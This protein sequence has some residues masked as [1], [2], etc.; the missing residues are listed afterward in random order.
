MSHVPPPPTAT[1]HSVA[2]ALLEC[3]HQSFRDGQEGAV[4]RVLAG[5]STLLV[6]PT[7]AGKSLCYQLPAYLYAQRSPCITLVISPLISL[8]EDQVCSSPGVHITLVTFDLT[9]MHI[10]LVT[11]DLTPMHITLV[12]FD[13][14]PMHITLVT[15]D[16]TPMHITLVT[17]DLTPLRCGV[18]HHVFTELACTPT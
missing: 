9:P 7:G 14:T 5:I 4:L 2:T 10:T 11:F 15:F 8:M 1:P 17:F 12:T 6:L 16:L 3:G 18:S 13:L